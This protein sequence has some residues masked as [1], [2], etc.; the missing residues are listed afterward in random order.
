M[1]RSAAPLYAVSVLLRDGPLGPLWA[2]RYRGS[3]CLFRVFP[4]SISGPYSVVREA[5]RNAARID[6]P[7][8][9]PVLD[10]GIAGPEHARG[11]GGLIPEGQL[12]A[13]TAAPT[14]PSLQ[15]HEIRWRE[16]REVALELLD[17]LAHL[18]AR[19][20]VHGDFGAGG[21]EL[22]ARGGV[23]LRDP[24]IRLAAMREGRIRN[25][26]SEPDRRPPEIVLG[27][28]REV[29]PWTDLYL[30][31]RLIQSVLGPKAVAE[32]SVVHTWVDRLLD[33]RNRLLRA[34]DARRVLLSL[35]GRS[36][37]VYAPMLSTKRD[38]P[39]ASSNELVGRDQ[40]CREL[41]D[42]LGQVQ[43]SRQVRLVLLQGPSGVGKT[44]VADWLCRRAHETG[45]ATVLRGEYGPSR[46]RQAG[47]AAMIM[48]Y[49]DVRGLEGDQ[50]Q[51]RTLAGLS[52]MGIDSVY[53]QRGIVDLIVRCRRRSLRSDGSL[54]DALVHRFLEACSDPPGG[55]RRPV[56][57]CLED[58]QLGLE[59][60]GFAR[61]LL[62]RSGE[63]PV[64]VLLTARQAEGEDQAELR[65]L[66][67]SAG[68][69]GMLVALSELPV[70]D[71]VRLVR[72]RLGVPEE[73]AKRLAFRTHGNPLHAVQLV[74]AWLERGL[75]R[76]DADGRLEMLSDRRLELPD[77]MDAVWLD[78]LSV[79][80]PS[81]ISSDWL[82]ME[83]AAV[84]GRS[85]D[86]AEWREVC[87]KWGV[88]PSE[89]LIAVLADRGL[90][91][92]DGAAAFRFA[93]VSLQRS[94]EKLARREGRLEAHHRACA[95]A[96]AE[97]ATD[98][99]RLGL[100][101]L[102][103]G[104]VEFAL[105][106][107]IQAAEER[108]QLGDFEHAEW[109]IEIWESTL[110]QQHSFLDDNRRTIGWTLLANVRRGQGRCADAI[111]IARRAEQRAR[112]CNDSMLLGRAL[113]EL[114]LAA[115]EIGDLGLA[116]TCLTQAEALFE[117]VEDDR[118][119]ARARLVSA[120]VLGDLGAYDD[121]TTRYNHCRAFCQRHDD[122]IGMAESI[123]GLG[124]LA[125]LRGDLELATVLL[126]QA[127]RE[128]EALGHP[129]GAASC[130][131]SLG[132]LSRAYGD[133]DEAVRSYRS[134]TRICR[135][136]GSALGAHALMNRGLVLTLQ[137]RFDDAATALREALK[138]FELID[139]RGP[140]GACHLYMLPSMVRAADWEGFDTHYGL[141]V[142][143]LMETEHISADVAFVAWTSGDL[144]LAK[145]Q[146]ERAHQ[147]LELALRQ[148]RMLGSMEEIDD[149]RSR[150]ESL[151]WPARTVITGE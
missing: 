125:V 29:G 92:L 85:V 47:L 72:D 17:I 129:W 58:V 106:P 77:A 144:A 90:V 81:R 148:Y 64:L 53:E 10:F 31:G 123:R 79:T 128:F 126:N 82:S 149:V 11:S 27:R 69:R 8:V 113:L 25:L 66:M 135:S 141:G 35:E 78:R 28:W 54:R 118:L 147:V 51:W 5:V 55:P 98:A 22:C 105:E 24:G 87:G 114:G 48:D 34:A 19:G 32:N 43:K 2:G 102:G 37:D 76:K 124:D 91:D 104:D 33:R 57:V 23:R 80:I 150:I 75:A 73:L 16:L 95:S 4:P 131:N 108:I 130:Y 146:D 139:A 13:I 137:G 12:Y 151:G 88:R 62:D 6:H 7:G 93:Y 83:I 138:S 133:L 21:V 45:V 143:L 20:L 101:H 99:E 107:L 122:G 120:G 15:E 103:S 3:E 40:V 112:W 49:L 142:A 68:T 121:A 38:A 65:A 39:V 61:S 127:R 70:E 46:S 97:S 74:E 136:S 132:N 59:S 140:L 36:A 84:L 117:G 1:S 116:L 44:A 18:H 9:A 119:L 71:Q 14:G 41:W 60:I 89:D 96:L 86:I 111:E 115:R 94:L 56:V 42:L 67:D 52:T 50:L 110:A 63:L 145:G 134:C 109:L 100:H 30:L 26:R